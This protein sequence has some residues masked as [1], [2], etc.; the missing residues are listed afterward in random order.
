MML[1]GVLVSF[2]SVLVVLGRFILVLLVFVVVLV[3]CVVMRRFVRSARLLSRLQFPSTS[4][5]QNV[6]AIRDSYKPVFV[7]TRRPHVCHACSGERA[8]MTHRDVIPR[9]LLR[10]SLGCASSSVR[11]TQSRCRKHDQQ[12][13]SPSR[14]HR[15]RTQRQIVRKTKNR[16]SR[17]GKVKALSIRR[18][19]LPTRRYRTI[20]D[21]CALGNL[22]Q[23]EEI[24]ILLEKDF[25][26]GP[27]P[28]SKKGGLI[29]L[30]A[31]A[32]A[33]GQVH[34]RTKVAMSRALEET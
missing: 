16:R 27:N 32:I 26:H 28:N 5:Q 25:L 23:V 30:A 20:K 17:V 14:R 12:R 22:K 33:L 4:R 2:R 7:S 9:R 34:S 31:V 29:G 11:T 10:I 18:K 13:A 15:Q 24:M 8:P 1:V 6:S 3:F 19:P 21:L